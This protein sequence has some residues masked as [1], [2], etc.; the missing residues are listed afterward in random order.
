MEIKCKKSLFKST[1]NTNAF[2]KGKM[3]ILLDENDDFYNIIDSMGHAFN[4]HKKDNTGTY[5]H[6]T[7]YFHSIDTS[8]KQKQSFVKK[9][10]NFVKR[11]L[12]S[13][14]K[15]PITKNKRNINKLT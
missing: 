14:F 1:Y 9:F 4:F 3:Y 10:G 8:Y 11:I 6:F 7:D 5:Y 12:N 2:T 15:N 13:D